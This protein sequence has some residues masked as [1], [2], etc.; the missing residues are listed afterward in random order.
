VGAAV[1]A[2]AC[3]LQPPAEVPDRPGRPAFA[4]RHARALLGSARRPY[5]LYLTLRVLRRRGRDPAFRHQDGALGA[6]R[7][8][9][10]GPVPLRIATEAGAGPVGVTARALCDR[11]A[12]PLITVRCTPAAVQNR[13][14][15]HQ[16]LS[17]LLANGELGK[18][19]HSGGLSQNSRICA[20]M[21]ITVRDYRHAR[22]HAPAVMWL[23]LSWVVVQ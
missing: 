10:R 4:W 7:E 14:A 6:P 18:R 2:G 23:L 3:P 5:D 1:C 8:A 15:P 21:R 19:D 17:G 11:S 16:G 20:S 12:M 13:L 9:P 22:L